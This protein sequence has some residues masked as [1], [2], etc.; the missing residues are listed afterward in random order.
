MD[1]GTDPAGAIPTVRHVPAAHG[2]VALTFDDG[3]DSVWT[4]PKLAL[5]DQYG[6][7]AS[8][9]A[10][11]Q[12]VEQS[13]DLVAQIVAAGSE[14]AN[15]SY[16][17]PYLTGLGQPEIYVE[18]DRTKQSILSA[19]GE[20]VPLFRAP[21]GDYDGRVLQAGADDGYLWHVLWDVDPRDWERPPPDIIAARV[22]SAATEGSIVLLH[23]WVPETVDV[24]GAILDALRS[25]GL[26]GT[27]VSALLGAPAPAPEQP[28]EPPP[29]PPARPSPRPPEAP[30]PPPGAPNRCRTLRVQTPYLRGDDVLTVQRALRK[31]HYDPGPADG[32]FGPLTSA[33][34][35]R[36]QAD[37]G[38]PVTGVVENEEYRALG[39][40]CYTLTSSQ[41]PRR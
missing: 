13:P 26:A 4:P 37:Q 25:R 9:F 31:R 27:T 15:H 41:R 28:P 7:R 5:L 20:F 6:A 34:V 24:L 1:H 35:R 21:Y 23:D 14:V 32:I 33:A 19:G 12:L 38:L 11:G 30:P 16:S 40:T 3:P 22:A 2:A 17:H 36:L 18:L 39:I 8:F 10:V 29:G